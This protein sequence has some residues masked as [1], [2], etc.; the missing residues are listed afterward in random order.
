MPSTWLLILAPAWSLLTIG[1][2]LRGASEYRRKVGEQA[3]FE[4]AKPQG[5]TSHSLEIFDR[6]LARHEADKARLERLKIALAAMIVIGLALLL[7]TASDVTNQDILGIL[8]P[9]R[10][11]RVLLPLG[12]VFAWGRLGFTLA[13]LIR[14]RSALRQELRRQGDARSTPN[15]LRS[16]LADD[17]FLDAYFGYYLRDEWDESGNVPRGTA[18]SFLLAY[19]AFFAA[20]HGVALATGWSALAHARDVPWMVLTGSVLIFAA[21]FFTLTHYQFARVHGTRGMHVWI[22]L[23]AVALVLGLPTLVGTAG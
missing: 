20:L 2:V 9:L 11:L 17:A 4:R 8:V 3:R 5:E 21:L 18:R 22:V 13:Q 14:D 1:L 7:N 16:L 10:L 23:G 6:L 12:V 15:A 19:V